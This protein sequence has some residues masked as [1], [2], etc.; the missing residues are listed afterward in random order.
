MLA[1]LV[2]VTGDVVVFSV[3]VGGTEVRGGVGALAK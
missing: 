2:V 3:V 1:C